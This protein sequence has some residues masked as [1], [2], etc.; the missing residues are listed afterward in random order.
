MS[1]IVPIA[2][3]CSIVFA[4]LCVAAAVLCFVV[5][6]GRWKKKF[7][8]VAVLILVATAWFSISHVAQ[9]TIPKPT[10]TDDSA[11]HGDTVNGGTLPGKTVT[12]PTTD[13]RESDPPDSGTASVAA[14]DLLARNAA[15]FTLGGYAPAGATARNRSEPQHEV[16]I[17]T[18][19]ISRHETSAG[20][21]C[22]FLNNAWTSGALVARETETGIT[23][24]ATTDKG[25]TPLLCVV[26]PKQSDSLLIFDAADTNGPFRAVS[27]SG[28]SVSNHPITSVS[29]YGAAYYCN[30]LSLQ[31]QLA[32][33]YAI[34]PSEN[35]MRI[36]G[37]TGYRL[38]TEAEW[39]YAA[40]FDPATGTKQT[41]PFGNRWDPALANVA[42]LAGLPNPDGA[43]KTRAVDFN[44]GRVAS[45]KPL[46]MAG[47]VWEWCQDWYSD[48]PKEK[49]Q[50]PEGPA[51]GT[52]KIVRGGSF[53]TRAESA[54]CA[55]R[56]IVDPT[57]TQPDIGFR[58]AISD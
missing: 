15:T 32:P 7:L 2:Y 35:W 51:T 45:T 50:D 21:Y 40:A 29:W 57:A 41:W 16:S 43:P 52:I 10:G 30:W 1:H 8:A 42:D 24:F 13:T 27:P 25:T 56:G 9:N 49:T 31:E 26:G 55:F 22:A 46:N 3:S 20:E 44:P 58:I 23:V 17:S 36:R 12:R 6:T 53:K 28:E 34:S 18:F 11:R 4:A 38:P 47:N 33:C 54:W 37:G 39:E 5:P 14:I 48:Y 19:G